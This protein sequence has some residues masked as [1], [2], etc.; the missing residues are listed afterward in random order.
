MG[1]VK[2]FEMKEALGKAMNVFW[3]K[4]YE[5][6]SLKDLLTAMDILNGSFYN[7]F[8]NKK[9]LFIKALEFYGEEI[10]SKRVA[11]ITQNGSFK[12]GVR[13][14]FESIY[15]GCEVSDGPSGCF[16]VNSLSG[17]LLKDKDILNFLQ[18][19]FQSFETFFQSELEKAV[20]SG[21]LAADLDTKMTGALIVTYIQGAM[22]KA[23]VSTPVEDLKQQTQFFLNA[24]NI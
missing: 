3:E 24:L 14:F 4:G 23:S 2:G 6:T 19:A 12:T 21:E 17:E 5:K 9:N 13:A 15:E 10:T 11:H 20:Q 22:K 16:L 1:R 7:T 8:G 18:N